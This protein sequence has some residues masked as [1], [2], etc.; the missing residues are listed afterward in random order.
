[1]ST[2]ERAFRIISAPPA[3]AEEQLE[4][5]RE[6]H[7]PMSFTV[8]VAKDAIVVTVILASTRELQRQAFAARQAMQPIK[9]PGL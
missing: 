7:A 6:T 5:L 3:E 8:S 2:S 4:A 9:L 1:M